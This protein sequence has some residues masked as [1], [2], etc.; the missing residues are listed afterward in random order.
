MTLKLTIGQLFEAWRSYPTARRKLQS[1]P[2]GRP[3]FLTGTHRSGTTWC[4]AMLAASG[5]WYIHEPFNPAKGKWPKTFTYARPQLANVE[6]DR[7]T[8]E[9]LSGRF[10]EALHLPY[11]DHPLMPLR[12][13][14]QPFRRILIKD[15]TACLL[16]GY[17]SN[18][19]DFETFVLFR[20]PAG[21]ASSVSR[22]KWPIAKF[23]RTLLA[24]R[25]LMEDHL[26]PHRKLLARHAHEEGI[27]ATATLHGALS[28][29]LWRNVQ[30]GVGRP[31]IFEKLC[32]APIDRFAELFALLDLP[33][34]D[35]VRR[36]HEALC[37]NQQLVGSSYAPHA[38][39]RNSFTEAHSWK[40]QLKQDD[41][42]IVREIWEQFGVPLYRHDHEWTSS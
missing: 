23:V 24:S 3:I 32:D 1:V 40:T 36:T 18:R 22:L 12:A 5:L 11:S 38:V 8:Q 28:A 16:T 27:A 31:L 30:Q 7:V 20:H 37:L 39:Q 29:V 42:A 9:I 21:F 2:R 19:F 25:P 14:P 26:A 4:G 34:D 35:N 33:Y 13:F 15:P 10:R 6:I 41:I 17:L